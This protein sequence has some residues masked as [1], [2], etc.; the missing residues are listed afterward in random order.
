MENSQKAATAL[1][2]L[3]LAC[4]PVTTLKEEQF[5][6]CS[7]RRTGIT[8]TKCPR[9]G[10][11]RSHVGMSGLQALDEHLPAEIADTRSDGYEASDTGGEHI[12]GG[13][14]FALDPATGG[15]LQF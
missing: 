9:R 4:C 11:R 13:W 15:C 8:L 7:S 6:P 5:D 2:A 3:D 1:Y 14:R 12:A 10:I